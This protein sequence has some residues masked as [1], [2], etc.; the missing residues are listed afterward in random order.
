MQIALKGDRF[1]AGSCV[2]CRRNYVPG[3]HGQGRSRL[4]EYGL[5]LLERQK[6]KGI[7]GLMESQFKRYCARAS[8]S[9][10]VTGSELLVFLERLLD[11]VPYVMGLADSGARLDSS[12]AM[13]SFALT[14]ARHISHCFWSSKATMSSRRRKVVKWNYSVAA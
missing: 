3:Q 2:L 4:S 14:A 5:Q 11:H 8:R 1:L 13:D 9:E 7:Y 10:E 12:F 6:A